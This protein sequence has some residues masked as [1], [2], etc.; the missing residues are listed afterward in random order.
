VQGGGE[1]DAEPEESRRLLAHHAAKWVCS[2][3][4]GSKSSSALSG[5]YATSIESN[6]AIVVRQ[7]DAH[8]WLRGY[9]KLLY[10][11]RF[12]SDVERIVKQNE[13]SLWLAGRVR[14]RRVCGHALTRGDVTR[15]G[16]TRNSAFAR[17]LGQRGLC[18]LAAGV[19]ARDP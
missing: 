3:P 8:A 19:Y 1:R 10:P 18:R 12:A 7:P 15:R 9:G 2:T 13:G 6:I 14:H 17:P 4:S 11:V 5:E 16:V